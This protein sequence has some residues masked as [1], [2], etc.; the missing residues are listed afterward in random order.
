MTDEEA[1]QIRRNGGD[2]PQGLQNDEH[3][4][5]TDEVAA[6]MRKMQQPSNKKQKRR[7]TG[8]GGGVG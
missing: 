6:L 5:M 1:A 7:S 3:W 2:I 8:T 4:G